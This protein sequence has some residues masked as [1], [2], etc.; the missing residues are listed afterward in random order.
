MSFWSKLLKGGAAERYQKGIEYFN[1]G[2]Y[3]KAARFLDDVITESKGRGSPIA[4]L[5]AFYA[6]EAHAKL[7]IAE[8]FNE[9]RRQTG[10]VGVIDCKTLEVVSILRAERDLSKYQEAIAKAMPSS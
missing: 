8:F 4:K 6:A 3:D 2:D 9:Y 10:T 1:D 7:G 5:S